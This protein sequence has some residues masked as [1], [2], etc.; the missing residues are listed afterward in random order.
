VVTSLKA[1][2]AVGQPY[3]GNRP[4]SEGS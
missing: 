2:A 3:Q 1:F 4:G